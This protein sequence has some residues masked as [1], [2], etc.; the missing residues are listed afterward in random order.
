MKFRTKANQ[1]VMSDVINL[2]AS[3][4]AVLVNH[5][6]RKKEIGRSCVYIPCLTQAIGISHVNNNNR[7]AC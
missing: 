1:Q 3:K 5:S 7:A 2:D 6:Q 4:I